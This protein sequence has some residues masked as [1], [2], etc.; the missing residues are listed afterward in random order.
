MLT[1]AHICRNRAMLVPLERFRSGRASI[2]LICEITFSTIFGRVWIAVVFVQPVKEGDREI[3]AELSIV[4]RRRFGGWSGLAS[5][6]MI[7][8]PHWFQN[9]G[10]PVVKS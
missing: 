6:D 10:I 9:M 4:S 2:S 8:E 3:Y 7:C 1:I 5:E